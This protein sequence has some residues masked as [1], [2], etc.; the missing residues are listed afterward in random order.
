[1][2]F[3]MPL[4]KTSNHL[5]LDF[6]K[7]YWSIDDIVYETAARYE[8]GEKTVANLVSFNLNAYPSRES[9]HNMN[10]STS[11]QYPFGGCASIAVNPV[12]YT[13]RAIFTT[14]EIFGDTVPTDANEQLAILYAYAK[15]YL[16]L[17]DV[18][19]VLEEGDE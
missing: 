12:L 11:P 6:E 9:K 18:V 4:S 13:W 1:M 10:S 19:D 14:T 8:D 15:N 7:A 17:S 2:G 16:G 5:F 3:L